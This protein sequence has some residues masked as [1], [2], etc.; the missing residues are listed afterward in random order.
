MRSPGAG[1]WACAAA[2]LVATNLA[3]PE[4]EDQFSPALRIWMREEELPN[5]RKLTEVFNETR[6]NTKCACTCLSLGR[7]MAL[8]RAS[9]PRYRKQV[10]LATENST[11]FCACLQPDAVSLVAGTCPGFTS[12]TMSQHTLI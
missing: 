3:R 7:L 6:E 5:G 2:K 12:A 11:M 8:V 10:D 9:G 1:A 4:L